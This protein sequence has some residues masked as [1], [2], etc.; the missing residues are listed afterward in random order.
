MGV[1]TDTDRVRKARKLGLELLFSDHVGDC[2]P[3]C[4]LA[5][6]ARGD[7]QAYVNLAAQGKYAESM[8]VLHRNVTL[9]A[10]IGRVCPAPCQEKCRRKPRR[11]G[12][13][14][15]IREIKRFVADSCL[16]EG[17]SATYPPLRRTAG[18][19]A[20]VAADLRDFP[21]PISCASRD[22]R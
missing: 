2:R 8:E 13:R 9:P 14:S 11:R 21:R 12:P 4:A 20:V 7:V 3:P 22:M 17:I 10:S 18:S 16:A 19:V 15:P 1:R 6:P 5:C